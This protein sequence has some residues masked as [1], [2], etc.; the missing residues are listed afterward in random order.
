MFRSFQRKMFG[1]SK[2]IAQHSMFWSFK[3][4]MFGV[5]KTIAQQAM[6]WSFQ[7]TMIHKMF[8][9]SK[10][11]HNFLCIVISK[12]LRNILFLLYPC[13]IF[14]RECA[15]L[16]MCLVRYAL[17]NRDSGEMTDYVHSGDS[18]LEWGR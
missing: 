18:E 6:F 16:N 13:F 14:S 7:T 11:L 1:F 2:S 10:R 9:V 8:G 3:R 4:K 5:S 15:M 17:T 12:V